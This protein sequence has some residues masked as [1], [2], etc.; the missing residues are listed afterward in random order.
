[1]DRLL[2][3]GAIFLLKLA[4]ASV[5]EHSRREEAVHKRHLLEKLQREHA[6]LVA[7]EAA[8][9]RDRCAALAQ[10]RIA[11]P[12]PRWQERIDLLIA[13]TDKP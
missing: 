10:L 11:S 2:M 7:L 4:E 6:R 13:T 3:F 5:T 12:D 8:R 9:A 1:M